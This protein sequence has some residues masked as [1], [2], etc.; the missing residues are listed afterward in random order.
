VALSKGTAM[1]STKDSEQSDGRLVLLRPSG[2]AG[3]GAE[4]T[5][6]RQV[7]ETLV[8]T[9]AARMADEGGRSRYFVAR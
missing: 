7:L 5:R 2:F 3:W 1:K 6:V 4:K 8:A 9:G